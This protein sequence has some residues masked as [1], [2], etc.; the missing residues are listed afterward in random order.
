M[1]PRKAKALVPSEQQDH[2]ALVK[3]A[4]Y[5]PKLKTLIHIANEYDGGKIGGYR[6][7]LMGV[8]AGV[9]DF[10][11]PLP[12][13]GYHGMWLELKRVEGGKVSREQQDWLNLMQELGYFVTVC[14]GF[15]DAVSKIRSYLSLGDMTK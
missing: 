6:R 4:K 10:F 2:L 8:K 14:Y 9:S 12:L 1:T 7:K 13:G 5:N 3:W 15:E 11:L